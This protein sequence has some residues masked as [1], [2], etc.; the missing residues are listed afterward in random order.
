MQRFC[1]IRITQKK[2]VLEPKADEERVDPDLLQVLSDGGE[3]PDGEVEGEISAVE[4]SPEN[5]LF[6]LFQGRQDGSESE[7]ELITFGSLILEG[8]TYKIAY[9]GTDICEGDG[10]VVTYGIQPDGSLTFHSHDSDAKGFLNKVFPGLSVQ[11]PS[12]PCL[13]FEDGART[14][15]AFDR[16]PDVCIHTRR[17]R[18]RMSFSAGGR[19]ELDYAVE[20]GGICIQECS[21][22][23][24]VEV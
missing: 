15:C 24:E 6:S 17:L 4:R 16:E 19:I 21:V 1:R 20:I 11:P 9:R 10:T 5:K 18:H 22:T 23:V 12:D 13:I 7:T 14:I 8:R 2:T 3:S